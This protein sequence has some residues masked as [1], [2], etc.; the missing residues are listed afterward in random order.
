MSGNRPTTRP[1]GPGYSA[2][3]SSDLARPAVNTQRTGFVNPQVRSDQSG[4]N[5]LADS[6]GQFFTGVARLSQQQADFEQRKALQEIEQENRDLAELARADRLQGLDRREEYADRRA[7]FESYDRTAAVLEAQAFGEDYLA[8]VK[9]LPKDD[10]DAYLAVRQQ[11]LQERFG[12]GTGNPI[13][14]SEFLLNAKKF[15]DHIEAQHRQDAYKTIQSNTVQSFIDRVAV[16]LRSGNPQ[17][18]NDVDPDFQRM[19]AI[20]LMGGDV[21]RGEELYARALVAAAQNPDQMGHVMRTM[22]RSGLDQ[23]FP[24]LYDEV[25]SGYARKVQ[26]PTTFEGVKAWSS[27]QAK[28]QAVLADP[29]TT[30]EDL[31]ALH[32]EAGLTFKQ[33]GGENNMSSMTAWLTREMEQRAQV[34]ADI[35][36]LVEAYRGNVSLP[37]TIARFGEG[38]SSESVVN[39]Q[40]PGFMATLMSQ[41]ELASQYPQLAELTKQGD[42]LGFLKSP[43]AS[44]EA[45]R[46]FA[47]PRT[48]AALGGE[49]PKPV[50]EQLK[51]TLTNFR[52]PQAA[53]VGFEFMRNLEAQLGNGYEFAQAVGDADTLALYDAIK[54][55]TAS[56][57]SSKTPADLIAQISSQP[58]LVDQ[59][60]QVRSGNVDWQVLTGDTSK[61]SSEIRQEVMDKLYGKAEDWLDNR[62]WWKI[63]GAP[64]V[65]GVLSE[66]RRELEAHLVRVLNYQKLTTGSVDMDKAVED[67]VKH[68]QSSFVPLPG[69]KGRMVLMKDPFGGRGRKLSEPISV[70][71]GQPVYS[72]FPIQT[73]KGIEDPMKTYR[74]DLVGLISLFPVEGANDPEVVGLSPTNVKNR[75]LFQVMD[76]MGSPVRLLPGTAFRTGQRIPSDPKE[77]EAYLLSKLPKG[78][79]IQRDEAFGQV[80]FSVFYGFRVKQ[81]IKEDDAEI[82]RLEKGR[83]GIQEK[84]R[85]DNRGWTRE[86]LSDVPPHPLAMGF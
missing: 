39:K 65:T 63:G 46:F 71:N 6:L 43:A 16:S 84:D 37:Q 4:L 81:G 75:G 30:V 82:N 31:A 12:T 85:L 78:F 57:T 36:L 86:L 67:T 15:S 13:F 25:S 60:K 73:S 66:A 14:D 24:S 79:Q 21:A 58:E 23:K 1:L 50:R 3:S 10:P 28:A 55:G 68:M 2:G 7:Y 59:M 64:K 53:S 34:T 72:P 33:H 40:F 27:L 42:P 44:F 76:E 74:E 35:N 61:K 54:L 32:Y 17:D 80:G 77:A 51:M 49:I 48:R 9:D 45:A 52:D 62:P 19:D 47:N 20:Q 26:A 70:V 38:A 69:Q 8:R 18:I 5:A 29:S 22:E 56:G 41:P 11:L 83:A